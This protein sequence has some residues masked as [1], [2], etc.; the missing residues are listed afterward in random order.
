MNG[1]SN[2]T[3][4]EPMDSLRVNSQKDNEISKPPEVANEPVKREVLNQAEPEPVEKPVEVSREVVVAEP[5]SYPEAQGPLELSHGESGVKDTHN[6]KSS[7][8]EEPR[9]PNFTEHVVSP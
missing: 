3:A 2:G 5:G 9:L 1:D 7:T 6:S 8:Q 4:G